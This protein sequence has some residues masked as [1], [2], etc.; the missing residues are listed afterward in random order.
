MRKIN[1]HK[2]KDSSTVHV[3]DIRELKIICYDHRG[4][5]YGIEHNLEDPKCTPAFWTRFIPIGAGWNT[6]MFEIPIAFND[7]SYC[8]GWPHRLSSLPDHEFIFRCK[9]WLT[10]GDRDCLFESME[11]T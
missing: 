8:Y 9:L 6:R 4:K 7:T 11:L 1:W 5:I 2:F 10:I 3:E